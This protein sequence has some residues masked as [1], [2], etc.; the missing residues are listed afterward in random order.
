MAERKR[1]VHPRALTQEEK[2]QVLGVLHE[3]RFV[4]KAPAEIFACLL[5]A[6]V[7][8]CSVSTMY[9]IL[10]EHDEVRERRNLLRHPKYSK[11]E[12][13]AVAPNQVWSWDITKLKGPVKGTYYCLYVIID[14]FSRY[15]VGWMVAPDEDAELAEALITE[16]CW[17]QSIDIDDE[18]YLHSDR[19]GPMISK[20]VALLLSELGVMKSLSRPYVSNDNPYSEAHFKTLKYRPGFPERFGSIQDARQ[21][22][23]EFFEWYNNDHYHSG[24]A[25]MTPATMHYGRAKLCSKT[26]QNVLNEAYE[27]HA[28]R[29][30]NGRPM[31]LQPPQEVWINKPQKPAVQE[32]TD[33]VI[34]DGT[35][36]SS[37]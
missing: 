31:S 15:V 18:L 26:R 21:F 30:I 13:M 24:I 10:R 22:C 27:K 12:L 9:R 7:Y 28:E 23:R 25:W 34:N 17:R 37:D 16:T 36:I 1:F 4:D 3:T 35:N 32:P 6:E 11:P 5:D 29:F 8:L 14:I 19:G 20:S 2:Q 33:A